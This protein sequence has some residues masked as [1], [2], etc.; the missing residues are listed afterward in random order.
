MGIA[1][2]R[3]M[4]WADMMSSEEREQTT[5]NLDDGPKIKRINRVPLL[6]IYRPL[7]GG[8]KLT[9][10]SRQCDTIDAFSSLHSYSRMLRSPINLVV[11]HDSVRA[12]N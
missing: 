7:Q 1:F 2:Q 9:A 8:F 3:A 4:L 12:M 10:R 5:M 11:H 6:Y